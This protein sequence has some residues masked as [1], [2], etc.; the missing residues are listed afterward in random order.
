MSY[1][2]RQFIQA[3]YRKMGLA[4]Y[5]YDITPDEMDAGLQDLDAMMATWNGKGIRLA[6][7][8]PGSPDYTGLD[9]DTSVPDSAWEA[10]ISNLA[11][12]LAPAY[13]KQV[14]VEVKASARQGYEVLL[15]RATAP[16]EMQFPGTMP[17]GAGNKPWNSDDPFF[18]APE[19]AVLTGSE[20][21]LEF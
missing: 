14:A 11:L 19:D 17:S 7:P 5:V 16:R 21:P 13:G 12:R 15:A 1:T 10:V 20:G 18:P 8:L 4:A 3:A 2:K 6:Y 9:E